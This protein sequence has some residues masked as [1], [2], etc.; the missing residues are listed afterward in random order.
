MASKVPY[1]FI[2]TCSLLDSC[3]VRQQGGSSVVYC[4]AKEDRFWKRE[5]S[6]L[7][8]TGAI[9]VPLRNYE[10]LIGFSEGRKRQ[11][12]QARSQFILRK[13]ESLIS[14]GRIQIVGDAND[15][16]ADA[17]L[18]SAALKFITQRSLVFIT[19]D[20]ALARDLETINQFES[21]AQKHRL[22]TKRIGRDGKIE[23]HWNHANL[24][25]KPGST[26]PPEETPANSKKTTPWWAV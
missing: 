23:N 25:E 6:A 4:Q 19:Q 3:W 26:L 13:M 20:R 9:I 15:P 21:I 11:E 18:L 5:F 7:E 17:I 10:E 12:L 8:K 16:F 2:D 22:R 1:I 14:A 24:T